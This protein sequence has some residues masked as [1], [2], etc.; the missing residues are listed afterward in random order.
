MW[1][2]MATAMGHNAAHELDPGLALLCC[3]AITEARPPLQALLQPVVA[4][5]P[6]S[7]PQRQQEPEAHGL[8]QYSVK[9][10]RTGWKGR[11]GCEFH[12]EV[13][14]TSGHVLSEHHFRQTNLSSPPLPSLPL[15]KITS[16]KLLL[17]GIT[18]TL[19]SFLVRFDLLVGY[20]LC[21]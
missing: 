1:A 16:W 3:G 11:N 12:Q 13:P 10:A 6:L 5:H 18:W 2:A 9:E 21:D 20:H 14:D 17:T 7:L 19:H 8:P 15:P 4:H